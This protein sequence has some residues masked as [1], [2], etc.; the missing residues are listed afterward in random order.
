MANIT[1]LTA[2][3]KKAISRYTRK[4]L[5][6]CTKK[7]N[8]EKTVKAIG[9]FYEF[10]GH[11]RPVVVFGKSPVQ[12]ILLD[13]LFDQLNGQL[14][15]QLYGLYG[16]LYGQLRDQ[17]SGQLNGQLYGQL[18]G[19]DGQLYGQLSDQLSGQLRGQLSDQL[20]GQLND[21]L[22]GLDGQLRG[23]LSDQLNGQLNDQLY[24]LDGQL[25]GQLSDQLSKI[26]NNFWI[27]TWWKWWAC[28]YDFSRYLGVEF[29]K[30]K[31]DLF[32]NFVTNVDLLIPYKK[33]VFV[34]EMATKIHWK[35]KRLHNQSGLA[36][37]YSDGWG[38]WMIDGVR[39]DEKI[40]MRPHELTKKDWRN[41]K[42][43]EVR[44]I[45]QER[46]GEDF[47]QKIGG[48]VVG[49]HK[50]PRIG[51]VIKVDISPD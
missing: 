2:T 40:V 23:Q 42:N 30:K 5:G 4:Y 28:F 44:R 32:I 9:D 14:N 21:Q 49:H 41:E 6:L 7:Q 11:E 47:A 51:D 25:R 46:M 16:Q 29:D 31:Y 18:Y 43:L 45:I 39:V 12:A 3:Q 36:L 34:S 37:E 20:N 38:L 27:T 17:L 24:G 8:R 26:K 1:K 35:N 22:Y 33:I 19:L 13:V 48:E 50:D 10:C 15:E